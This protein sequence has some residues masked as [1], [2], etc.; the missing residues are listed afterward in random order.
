VVLITKPSCGVFVLQ[1]DK[2]KPEAAAAEKQAKAKTEAA[3]A[4]AEAEVRL[5]Y[6]WGIY[7]LLNFLQWAQWVPKSLKS[8]WGWAPHFGT[9]SRA[10][11][12]RGQARWSTYIGSLFTYKP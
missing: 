8:V 6:C 1:A 4:A 10:P 3:A 9:T 11:S 2:P 5:G 12:T 7:I